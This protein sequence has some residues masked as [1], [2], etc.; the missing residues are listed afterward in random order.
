MTAAD[1]RLVAD[2][3]VNLFAAAGLLAVSYGLRRTMPNAPVARRTRAALMLGAALFVARSIAWASGSALFS[4][5][6]LALAAL[7]PVAALVVAEGLLRRHAPRLLK[8]ALPAAAAAAIV[9]GLVPGLDPAVADVVLLAAV[10]GGF[11]ASGVLLACRD[12]ASLSEGE[13]AT[14]RRVVG[15]MVLLAPLIATDFSLLLPDVPVRLG[16]LGA[17]VMLYI[18]FGPSSAG[19][20]GRERLLTLLVFCLV[21]VLLAAGT[22]LSGDADPGRFARNAA[23]ALS[24]LLFAAL[25]SELAGAQAERRKAADPLLEARDANDFVRR[26]RRH[27]VIGDA[28][29]LSPEDLAPL[30]H[31]R[32]DSLLDARPLLRASDAPW[33]R[34]PTDDGVERAASLLSTYGATH[35]MRLSRSPLRIAVITLPQAV[36]DPRMESELR[37]AQRI[38]ELVFER[39]AATP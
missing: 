10:A 20:R 38:G 24:G 28:R 7:T 25:V 2:V 11:A 39:E 33:G 31:A 13:N 30:A 5:L 29:I 27:A 21:A 16:A 22:W 32:F 4:W 17:L 15:A 26:L 6:T 18:G 36:A 23:I 34:A 35:A 3:S 37:A 9:V 8:L 19:E 12:R 1:P 14:I